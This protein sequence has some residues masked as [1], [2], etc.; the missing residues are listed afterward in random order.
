MSSPAAEP[1]SDARLEA[2]RANAQLSTGPTSAE[3]KS[4]SSRNAIK[5]GLSCRETNLFFN[6]PDEQT[7]FLIHKKSLRNELI[8]VG[9]VEEKLFHLYAFCLFQ[10]QRAQVL[11]LAATDAWLDDQ[12][13]PVLIANMERMARYGEI[14]ERRAA[15]TL[16]EIRKLQLDRFAAREIAE[17]I[18]VHGEVTEISVALP[19]EKLRRTDLN[20]TNPQQIADTLI[21]ADPEVQERPKT[22]IQNEPKIDWLRNMLYSEI[23]RQ[24]ADEERGRQ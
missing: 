2:N 6:D 1:I 8:P 16:N 22:D 19:C 23:S 18:A 15:R 14:H 11:E 7:Q 9:E 21:S 12:T 3:G 5:H 4:T 13:N 17:H 10:A 24:M 20:K